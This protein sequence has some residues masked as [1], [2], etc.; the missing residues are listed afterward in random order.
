MEQRFHA[1]MRSLNNCYLDETW[2]PRTLENTPS[3]I[4]CTPRYVGD[5]VETSSRPAPPAARSG[6][7]LRSGPFSTAAVAD[8]ISKAARSCH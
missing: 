3:H 6:E 4:V 8:E 1:L 2:Q 7:F 5:L